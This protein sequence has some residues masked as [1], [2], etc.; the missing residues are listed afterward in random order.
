LHLAAIVVAG[1][2]VVA[3][4]VFLFKALNEHFE[5]QHEINAKLPPDRKFEPLFWSF[6]TR[7]KFR[8]LQEEVLPDTQ[9][10][11]TYRR[12]CLI[13]FVLFVS[14]MLLL[15]IGLGR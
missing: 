12:F 2:F 5:L 4:Y 3:A 11:K 1:V 13:G 6:G 9:R 8:D 14:G 15:G 10:L 7:L